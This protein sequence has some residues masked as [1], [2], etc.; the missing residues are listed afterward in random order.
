MNARRVGVEEDDSE[1]KTSSNMPTKA[2]F[3]TWRRFGI[4]TVSTSLLLAV[5]LAGLYVWFINSGPAIK[6]VQDSPEEQSDDTGSIAG[7]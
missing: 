7:K 5:V 2:G 3:C 1:E 6:V 4:V